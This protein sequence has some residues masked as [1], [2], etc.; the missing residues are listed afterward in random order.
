MKDLILKI[1]NDIWESFPNE[2]KIGLL[3]GLSGVALFYNYLYEIYGDDDYQNKLLIIVEKI[4]SSLS[5]VHSSSSLCDGLAGY[6]MVLLKLQNK[7]I[8]IDED[9]FA[10]LDEIILE[11]LE[12]ECS[13][14]NY[15]FLH[16]AMGMAMYFIERYKT[17]ESLPIFNLLNSFATTLINKI[18][19]DFSEV[20]IS[21]TALNNGNC[22]YFGIAHGVAGYINFLTYLGNNFKHL[23]ADVAKSLKECL[24]YLELYK[25]YNFDSKQY[26]P[27]IFLIETSTIHEARLAWCQGDMG[28]SNC[29]FNAGSLLNENYLIE[30]ALDLMNNT[31]LIS[32]EE[33]GVN[34]ISICHGSTGIVLQYK[35]AAIRYNLDYSEEI[36]RWFDKIREQTRNFEEFLSFDGVDGYNKSINILDGSAGLGLT[37]LTLEGKIDMDWLKI[38]NLH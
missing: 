6:G 9:Y 8:D 4:N 5:E 34:D 31:R 32:I 19:K 2:N 37:I 17:K 35:L 11:N 20:L 29:L 10:S 30:D 36:N 16:G 15:D 22:Y 25:K 26:Y 24:N 28:V 14:N 21:E 7:C 18:I 27:N 1:E 23:K 12:K 33:A 13:K 38:L 3:T